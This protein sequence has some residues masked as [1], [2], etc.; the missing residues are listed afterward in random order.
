M[1]QIYPLPTVL[2]TETEW[3][4]GKQELRCPV[5]QDAYQ[6]TGS[7]FTIH[8][9]DDYKAGWGG[10][11]DLLIIPVEG[12]CGHAWELCLGFHKGMTVAFARTH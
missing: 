10:R 7:P 5:C 6:R 1:A 8:G 4:D 9:M 3:P 11:G 12:E 2:G